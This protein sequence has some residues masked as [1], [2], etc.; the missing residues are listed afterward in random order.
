MKRVTISTL[1][2]TQHKRIRELIDLCCQAEPIHLSLPLPSVGEPLSDECFF[3][4]YD[5]GALVSVIHLF[6]PDHVVGELIG[7]TH[8][9]HRGKGH[10]RRLLDLA[11]DHADEIGLEQVYVISDGLSSDANLA[12]T[13][14][15]LEPEY[16]EYMLEKS[17]ALAEELQST[18]KAEVVADHLTVEE[19]ALSPL[20]TALFSDIFRTDIA[21]C[22]AYL[23]EIASNERIHTY[24]LMRDDTPIGQTQLTL[25]DDMAYISGFGILPDYRRNGY[26]LSFLQQLEQMLKARSVTKLTLQVSDQN[27]N[28]LSLY[29]KD[30]FTTLEAL[31]YHPLFEE[32]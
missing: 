7:F 17:L 20:T 24:V 15:G 4:L 21:Q 2:S 14:L 32:G 8:P 3:A 19:T 31:H 25:I 1:N 6:Y 30:G 28:A 29:R 10:F 13:A 11:L 12:L 26:G 16:T 5:G 9:D 22:E 18:H 27:K 23:K